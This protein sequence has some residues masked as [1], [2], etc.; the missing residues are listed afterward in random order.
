MNMNPKPNVDA[1]SN[2]VGNETRRVV[3]MMR[4]V[5][6]VGEWTTV[7]AP[8]LDVTWDAATSKTW[9]NVTMVNPREPWN[10]ETDAAIW[11]CNVN[12]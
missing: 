1:I 5:K 11:E 2:G 8:M 9:D 3:N 12:G 10:I 7:I 4:A 6:A